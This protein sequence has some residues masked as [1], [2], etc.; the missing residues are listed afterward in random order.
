MEERPMFGPYTPSYTR[1]TIGG[2][3]ELGVLLEGLL[4][5]V[6]RPFGNISGIKRRK[7]KA[8]A[9]RVKVLCPVFDAD[10]SLRILSK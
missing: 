6:C 8:I 7:G 1:S 2:D 4:D 9:P 10:T 3:V 5:V